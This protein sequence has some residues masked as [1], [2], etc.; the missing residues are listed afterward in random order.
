VSL[1]AREL[2]SDAAGILAVVGMA[3]LAIRF[4]DIVSA[5][6]A[7]RLLLRRTSDKMALLAFARRFFKVTVF[8]VA[9]ILLL[10][11]VGVNV[12]AVLAGLGIG[13][14]A[15]ALAAQK[16]LENVFGGIAIIMRDVV[17]VGD[18]CKIAGQL[19]TIEDVGFAS[20]RVRT[21]DRTVLSVSNAQVSQTSIENYTMREKIWLHHIFG[22]R[23]DTSVEEMRQVLA[24]VSKMLRAHPKLESESARIRLIEFGHSSLDVEVFA[25][26]LETDYGLFLNAQEDV[27]L[28]I[29]SIVAA[30]GTHLALP[31][32]MNYLGRDQRRGAAL[33]PEV[34]PKSSIP[35]WC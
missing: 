35:D 24:E 11:T 23:Y 26:V 28:Q 16:T 3:W 1:L 34:T 29:M 19:G 27:L 15:V 30:S 6:G 10:R 12:S 18:F 7:R 31:S 5:S 13:G 9:V 4:S 32:Q 22:L 25:Y 20:T 14:I 21:L 2:W 33:P 17:R 8:I